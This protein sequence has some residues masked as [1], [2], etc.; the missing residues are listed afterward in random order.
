MCYGSLV[1]QIFRTFRRSAAETDAS[2]ELQQRQAVQSTGPP[3]L[4]CRDGLDTRILTEAL[5]MIKPRSHSINSAKPQ[6]TGPE[7]LISLVLGSRP[8]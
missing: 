6:V 2:P 1:I 5:P 8:D 4:V 7:P 3:G